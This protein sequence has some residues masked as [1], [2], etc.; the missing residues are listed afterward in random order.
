M[1]SDIESQIASLTP[2]EGSAVEQIVRGADVSIKPGA[3]AP[4]SKPK[5]IVEPAKRATALAITKRQS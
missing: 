2:V 1:A 4:G 5:M 3:E